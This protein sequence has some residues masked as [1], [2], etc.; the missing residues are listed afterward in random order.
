MANG[1]VN[2]KTSVV[3]SNLIK[4]SASSVEARRNEEKSE[5]WEDVESPRTTSE[6][7]E[8]HVTWYSH[9]NRPIFE[10]RITWYSHGNQLISRFML[11][12]IATETTY[13]EIVLPAI[14]METNIIRR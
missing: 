8:I 3:D 11:H 14:T 5:N 9:G 4:M 13:L 7:Q 2:T 10:I 1:K 6:S 12:G